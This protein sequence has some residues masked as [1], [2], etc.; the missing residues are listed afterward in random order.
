MKITFND[1]GLLTL[2]PTK[3]EL[4]LINALITQEGIEAFKQLVLMWTYEEIK[5]QEE[6]LEEKQT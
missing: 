1:K 2:H 5:R 4:G 3:V 6:A